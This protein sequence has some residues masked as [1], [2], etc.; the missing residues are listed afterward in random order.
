[1]Q[2]FVSIFC[3]SF[4]KLVADPDAFIHAEIK[5]EEGAEWPCFRT[6]A[7][8]R[9][10]VGPLQLMT[11]RATLIAKGRSRA[12]HTF[13]RASEADVWITIDD[14][15]EATTA[16]LAL[17]LGALRDPATQIVIAPCAMRTDLRLNIVTND[18]V[19]RE[20]SEG[21]RLLEIDA[22][23]A[24]L[25]GYK[26]SALEAMAGRFPDLWYVNAPDDIGIGLFLETIRDHHWIGEDM[27][28]CARAREAGVRI[29]SLVD[30][31][32]VHAGVPATVN[33]EWLGAPHA[34][35]ST[36]RGRPELAPTTTT[37]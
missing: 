15:I 16:D 21:V 7:R 34:D 35:T 36:T 9:Q 37:A 24:A 22:G 26:R 20:T 30:T 8:L 31:A 13:L 32:I 25:V 5:A 33:A 17:L 14:D 27:Q 1:M 19:L 10:L 4:S 29:E 28:F 3:Y 6:L 23:G 12:A 18:R 2:V 11:D